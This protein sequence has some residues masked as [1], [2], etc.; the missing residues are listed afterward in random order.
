MAAS[1]YEY[2]CH[3]QG[4][5]SF[6]RIKING[7]EL[8]TGKVLV[9]NVVQSAFK[10]TLESKCTFQLYNNRKHKAKFTLELLTKMTLSGLVTVLT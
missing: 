7:I 9:K 3:R 10:H 6:F 4:I 5:G 2:A 1:C 8:S